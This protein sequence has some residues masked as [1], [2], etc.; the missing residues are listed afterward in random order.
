MHICSSAQSKQSLGFI[1]VVRVSTTQVCRETLMPIVSVGCI[2]VSEVIRATRLKAS[3]SR[4][5]E[6][7]TAMQDIATFNSPA[8]LTTRV[9]PEGNQRVVYYRLE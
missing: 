5:N 8:K 7:I 3:R 9:A 2:V 4:K 6:S 1:T